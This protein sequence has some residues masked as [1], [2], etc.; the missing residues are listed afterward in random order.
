MNLRTLR[1]GVT[2][3][4]TLLFL[5][6][7]AIIST[8]ITA[9]FI[10]TQEARVLQH[11]IA[12]LEDSGTQLVSTMSKTARR[13]ET[14]IVPAANT[15]GSILAL[16]MASN[17]EFPTIMM[18][19]GSGMVL[20]Q[21]SQTSSLLSPNVTISDLTFKNVGGSNVWFSFTL[22]TTVRTVNPRTYSRMFNGTATLF[23]DD[24]S[25]AGGCGSCPAPACI[26]HAYTWYIC[27]SDICSQSDTTIPC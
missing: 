10:S 1:S 27:A 2:L 25:D 5:G 20:A 11:A 19:A 22:S 16:Q 21:K 26:N 6:I 13:A 9:V 14:V 7:L 15:T 17:D 4:E 23:P 12:E 18:R 24:Q 8:T 3:L